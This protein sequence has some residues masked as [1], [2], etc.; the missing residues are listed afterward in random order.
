MSIFYFLTFFISLFLQ[1]ELS[2]D[3]ICNINLSRNLHAVNNG[4]LL[5]V[6][7]IMILSAFLHRNLGY[8][9]TATAQLE[10]WFG[11]VF[12]SVHYRYQKQCFSVNE[13]EVNK[14]PVSIPSGWTKYKNK[15][16]QGEFL[17]KKNH[18]QR[19]KK[20][21][22]GFHRKKKF[23]HGKFKTNMHLENCPL[24]QG[25]L[26]GGIGVVLPFTVNGKKWPVDD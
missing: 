7:K 21:C 18:V 12:S 26:S 19:V 8:F 4:D 16:L 10:I 17:R 23:S 6:Q 13:A 5:V 11:L 22:K 14:F 2:N 9:L 15:F 24:L 20:S 1:T 3:E 25:S